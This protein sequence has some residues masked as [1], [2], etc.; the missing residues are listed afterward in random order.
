[1]KCLPEHVLN[2]ENSFMPLQKHEIESDLQRHLCDDDLV[3]SGI[4]S[5]WKNFFGSCG[6]S[7]RNS[8]THHSHTTHATR[9]IDDAVVAR[10]VIISGCSLEL[11]PSILVITFQSKMKLSQQVVTL[12]LTVQAAVA[13][14][15]IS[16]GSRPYYLIDQMKDSS[17][18]TKL[19]AHRKR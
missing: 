8:T 18:K 19:G 11:L 15:I 10:V 7:A 4:S 3:P 2:L 14:D 16:L 13:V 9:R 5:T 6:S 12:L 1:M 17:L